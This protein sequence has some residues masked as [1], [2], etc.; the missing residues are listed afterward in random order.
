MVLL[1]GTTWLFAPSL[2]HAL[3]Y[4]SSLISQYETSGQS[5]SW[6]FRLGDFMAGAL[7]VWFVAKYF[8]HRLKSLPV[9]L[10]L[11][12]G[13]GMMLDPVLTTT[14]KVQGLACRETFSLNFLLHAIES[15]FTAL[16]FFTL[17]V[18]DS[19]KRKK[20]VSIIFVIFQLAYGVLF[21]SQYADKQHFNTAS[22]F[23]YQ[24]LVLVW[25]AW[26]CRDYLLPEDALKSN[27]RKT[28]FVR[29]T[30]AA[31][32]FL[33]G[34]LSIMISLAHIHLLG[35]IKG[36][37]FAGDN[38]W[39]AQH[40][41]IIGVI[42]LYLS[43]H[44]LRGELRARQLFLVIIGVEVLQYAAITPNLPL[45]ALYALTFSGLF[46]TASDFKRGVIPMTWQI[47]VK[48]LL[49]MLSALLI[50][51]VLALLVLDRDNRVS[52]VA[53]RSFDHFSDYAL[54]SDSIHTTHRQSVLL[55]DTATSF[56]GISAIALIWIL[57]RPY[58]TLPTETPDFARVRQLLEKHSNSSED[59]F[60]LW[61]DDKQYFWPESGDG[62]IAYKIVG[63]VAF[64]LA[65][66]IAPKNQRSKLANQ[67][68]GWAQARRLRACFLPVTEAS[69]KLYDDLGNLQIGSS[70]L[71]AT[72]EF[73]K[74]TANDKWWRWKRN[75]AEKQSYRYQ[76]SHPPHSGRLM[77]SLR[78]VSDQWLTK[79][80]RQER[81]FALGYFDETYLQRCTIHYLENKSGEAVAFANQLPSL[82][83]SQ[84]ATVDLLRHKSDAGEAMPYLLF[85]LIETLQPGYKY[86]DLGFVPFAETSGPIQTIARALSAGRFSAKGL[87]QFKNKFNP[88]WQS[89]YLV[90]DGDLADLALIAINLEKAME[91]K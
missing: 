21:A 24:C 56:I 13:V 61:P 78:A 82:K 64:A 66:P 32:A 22:Q 74:K 7:V 59:Y 15:T 65:D 45:L 37:Y 79:D 50:A 18:Y 70:A 44:I 68:V 60:K 81:G 9:L 62:F 14:C 10:V 88:E 27:G 86:F 35:R 84:T 48:D 67:F 40:G 53:A 55:A 63:P 34:L 83:T 20:I 71:V 8:K 4:R 25:L 19:V 6:L 30:I 36:L 42:M 89:C 91:I 29:W 80:G 41:V 54:H 1:A 39:L 76:I 5:Y 38:A 52:Q 51:A 46:V 2:N 69:L 28:V 72:D 12:I 85:K 43:R 57:F 26:F 33:N 73:I 77:L 3:S 49:Y 11:V 23:V 90:Y 58:K 17:A 47:R 16:A 75:R 87:E 31:W